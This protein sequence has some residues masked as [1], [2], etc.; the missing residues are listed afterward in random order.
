MD[1][2]ELLKSEE[3]QRY[4]RIATTKVGT[5][6]YNEL[7]VYIWLICV[8]NVFL[9]TIVLINLYLLIKFVGGGSKLW[10]FMGNTH[11]YSP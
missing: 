4:L 11:C 9:L 6:L 10:S 7:Y 2:A 8:Y 1:I 5:M 3:V